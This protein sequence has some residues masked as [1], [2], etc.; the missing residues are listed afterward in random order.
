MEGVRQDTRGMIYTNEGTAQTP[1]PTPSTGQQTP[2]I[3]EGTTKTAFSQPQ[4]PHAAPPPAPDPIVDQNNETECAIARLGQSNLLQFPGMLQ[5]VSY[6]VEHVLEGVDAFEGWV[7]DLINGLEGRVSEA[8]I[9]Q[10]SQIHD[11][12]IRQEQQAAATKTRERAFKSC[13][14]QVTYETQKVDYA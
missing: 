2:S 10:Q 1:R 6:R 7:T 4:P 12:E 13:G 8:F 3:P 5:S 11:I 14:N 9:Q